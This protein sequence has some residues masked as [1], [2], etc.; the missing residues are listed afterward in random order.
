MAGI[1]GPT[2]CTDDENFTIQFASIVNFLVGVIHVG[3]RSRL[4]CV[5][6]VMVVVAAVV[7]ATAKVTI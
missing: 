5:A 1:V 3:G 6:V 2:Y 7:T 4:W